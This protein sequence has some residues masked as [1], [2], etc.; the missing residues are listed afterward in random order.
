[1][2]RA[3]NEPTVN[4]QEMSRQADRTLICLSKLASI[5]SMSTDSKDIVVTNQIKQM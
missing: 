5:V 4:S 2:K 3:K 1:M